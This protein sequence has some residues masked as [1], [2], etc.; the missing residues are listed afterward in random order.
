MHDGRDELTGVGAHVE[1]AGP[2]ANTPRPPTTGTEGTFA[3][4][5]KS[6]T[7]PN[8]SPPTSGQRRIQK[9]AHLMPWDDKNRGT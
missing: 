1:R 3:P 7:D 8:T 4:D 6:Y 9:G 2:G 5:F